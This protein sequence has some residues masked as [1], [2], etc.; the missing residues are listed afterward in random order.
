MRGCEINLKD[1]IICSEESESIYLSSLSEGRLEK[2]TNVIANY[3]PPPQK[4]PVQA[5]VF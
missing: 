1:I 5:G 4:P 2:K 3:L